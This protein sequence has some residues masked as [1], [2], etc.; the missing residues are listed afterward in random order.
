MKIYLI[1]DYPLLKSRS[2]NS[3]VK[4]IKIVLGKNFKIKI[5]NP[6]IILNRLNFKNYSIQKWL[7]YID[8]YIL[9]GIFLF[10]KI[11][12]ND[13]V[14]IC[15]QSNSLLFPFIKS[16]KLILTC[17]DLVNISLLNNKRLQ[18][19]SK[20]SLIS[21]VYHKLILHFII[22]FKSIICVSKNTKKELQ[23][24]MNFK[25]KNI[26]TIHQS[27]N[28][29]FYKINYKEKKIFLRKKKINFKFFLHVG[30]DAWY[31]NKNNLI[32][33]FFNFIKIN[34]RK[35]FKLILIGDYNSIE[36]TSLIRIL[37]LQEKIIIIKNIDINDLRSYYSTAEALIFPSIVEGF[38]WP[39]VEAQKCGIPVF[40]TNKGPMNE[41]GSESVFY[42]NSSNPKKS[43]LIIDEK[44][45]LKN[46]MIKKGFKNIKRFNLE[47]FS[48]KMTN[49]YSKYE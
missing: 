32:K 17:H 11:K 28:D 35:N 45:R 20:Q 10:F 49:V 7:G 23:K 39:I 42:I 9:F 1:G 48:S 24:Y 26:Y 43:A 5:I 22:K 8:N 30:I 46:R 3:Y 25:D 18:K 36:L 44:L 12:R 33:I 31:K 13:L 16:K 41:V 27:L 14:H 19:F 2:M 21:K 40:T 15:N 38:G 29:N 34:K 6:K 37:Q 47:N 4:L